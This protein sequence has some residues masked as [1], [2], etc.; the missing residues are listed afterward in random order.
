MHLYEEHG[1]DFA[2]HLE[3]MFAIASVGRPARRLVLV[4][5]QLGV[6]PLY[7]ALGAEG[8]AFASEVKSLIAGDL[9]T[10]ALDPVAA[11]LFLAFGY[12]P[13]PRSLFE[14]VRS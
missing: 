8:L 10:P 7:F 3:G 6:K 13:G 14:G 9:L 5:D 2:R 11:E 4:R 12:V 1:V